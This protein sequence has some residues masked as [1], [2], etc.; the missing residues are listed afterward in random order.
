MKRI[1]CTCKVEKELFYFPKD[2]GKKD[3]LSLRCK[4]CNIER[5]RKQRLEQNK[6]DVKKYKENW[7]KARANTIRNRERE[8]DYSISTEDFFNMLQKQDNK[9]LICKMDFAFGNVKT[10]PHVDHDHSCC[11]AGRSCGKCIRGLLCS[12]CN[13]GLGRFRDNPDLLNRAA[14]YLRKNI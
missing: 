1:C 13:Q 4:Q 7:Y 10:S 9:C 8:K 12:N 2:K 3:G 11:P 6:E 5:A 14:D